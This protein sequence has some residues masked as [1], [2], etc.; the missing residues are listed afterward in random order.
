[1]FVVIMELISTVDIINIIT[2][3]I[4]YNKVVKGSA[5]RVAFFSKSRDYIIFTYFCRNLGPF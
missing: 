2:T 4:E 5:R 1:M 3:I